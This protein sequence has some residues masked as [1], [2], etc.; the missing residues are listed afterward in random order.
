MQHHLLFTGMALVLGLGTGL[1]AAQATSSVPVKTATQRCEAAVIDA[2]QK[3]RGHTAPQV[4]WIPPKRSPAAQDPNHIKGQGRYQNTSGLV[5]FNYSCTLNPDNGELIG[6]VLS[7]TRETP[8]AVEKPWQP[9]LTRLSPEGCE[10]AAAAAL[11][12][13]IPRV[14]NIVFTSGARQLKPA[15]QGHTYLHGTGTLERVAGMKPS[16]FNYRCELETS[17][18]QFLN[19]QTDLSD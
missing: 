10:T 2:I 7:D 9:D 3:T 11:K 6:V 15:P 17:S 5:P 8:P 16:R 18:G 19:V 14:D 12:A 13:K 4:Q 1:A